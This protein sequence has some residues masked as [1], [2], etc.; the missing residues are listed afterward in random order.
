LLTLR[1]DFSLRSLFA[2][3]AFFALVAFLAFE[4]TDNDSVLVATDTLVFLLVEGIAD[5][6]CGNDKSLKR[7]LGIILLALV[8]D[9]FEE[10]VG[11]GAGR[12]ERF[13]CWLQRMRGL[14][15]GWHRVC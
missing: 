13:N 9:C 11:I 6:F 12:N 2:G 14:W 10:L 1:S 3:I 4:A 8:D 7:G 15:F 5:F